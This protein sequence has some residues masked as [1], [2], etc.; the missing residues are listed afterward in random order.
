MRGIVVVIL[1]ASASASAR[2]HGSITEGM[3]CGACHTAAGWRMATG[4]GAGFDHARTGFPLVGAH[5]ATACTGCHDGR[6]ELSTAC[7][8]C[9]AVADP[10]ARKLGDA[11]EECHRPVDWKD[12]RT[13]ERHR[14]THLP[15]TGAHA[16]IDCANCHAMTTERTWSNVPWDCYACHRDDYTRHDI[17]PIHDGS[18][19]QPAFSHFC[20]QCHRTATWKQAVI[21]PGMLP[22]QALVASSRHDASMPISSGKHRGAVCA[23]C[24]L[25]VDKEPRLLSCVGCHAHDAS[26]LPRAHRGRLVAAAAGDC[27]SCHPAGA[28]R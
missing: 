13:L 26:T 22:G 5:R 16:I 27:L 1:L 20:A 6:T 23:S 18:A 9:H 25:S 19:G 12:T 8:G 10:H 24:H 4:G 11:C 7:A 21:V 17:H 28:R 3:D 2:D 14:R 15:L